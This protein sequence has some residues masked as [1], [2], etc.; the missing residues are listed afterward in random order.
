MHKM[1]LQLFAEP[2]AANSGTSEPAEQT[3]AVTTPPTAGS[4]PGTPG[5]T[6][7]EAE[8]EALVTDK[9]TK[10]ADA[11]AKSLYQQ[12]GM[13]EEQAAEAVKDFKAKQAA[14]A[15][16]EKGDLTAMQK[17]AEEAKAEVEKAKAD[18]FNDLIDARTESIAKD[19]GIDLAKLPYVRLDFSK[20]GKDEAGKPKKDDIKAV[21]EAALTA[22]PDLKSKEE[23]I[24]KGVAPT[25]G[26]NVV[27]VENEKLRR[28]FGLPLE[29]K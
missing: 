17:K 28:A 26:S 20:V 5:K 29:K 23:P 15:E 3:T 7:T 8:I 2:G 14:K 21:L 6:Y 18:A 9:A 10:K 24:K 19:L 11:I 12:N 13:T 1:N 22:M 27:T 16:A 4:E 25:N